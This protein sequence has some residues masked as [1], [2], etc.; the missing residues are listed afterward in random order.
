MAY[1][2]ENWDDAEFPLAYLITIRTHGTWL[3][4][5]ERGSV[6]AHDNYNVVGTPN[7]PADPK[8]KAVMM[9]NMQT[10]KVILN[11]MQRAIVR[12]AIEEV[13]KNRKYGLYA[14]NVR[15]NHAHAV[16]RAEIK[17]ELVADSFKAY[18]TRKLHESYLIDKDIK[19]WSRGRSRRYL[20]KPN[21]VNA[22]I[23][24]VTFCQSDYPFEEWYSSKFND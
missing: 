10:S 23:D 18:A 1:F 12:Q 21:H 24:Y 11:T 15:S 13:W 2:G 16:V 22:A 4:G 6:D 7:R 20:W 9:S 14:L 5:E 17:P 3:H 8:L 19:P